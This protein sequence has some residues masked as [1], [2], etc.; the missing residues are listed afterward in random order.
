MP[1]RT[2]GSN[3]AGTI[4]LFLTKYPW[5][6]RVGYTR[7]EAARK[8]AWRAGAW[9]ASSRSGTAVRIPLPERSSRVRSGHGR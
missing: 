8:A 9:P 4:L 2:R 7:R 3:L 6:R 1:R 5:Y